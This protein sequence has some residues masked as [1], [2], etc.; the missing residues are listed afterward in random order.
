MQVSNKLTPNQFLTEGFNF[1][2]K[3]LIWEYRL[4]WQLIKEEFMLIW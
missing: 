3:K 1:G 4:N 2:T